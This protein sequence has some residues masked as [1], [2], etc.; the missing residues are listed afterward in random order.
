MR[1][2][3]VLR[4]GTRRNR[5]G[6]RQTIAVS[7]N[8]RHV[9]FDDQQVDMYLKN[10]FDELNRATA[11]NE[12]EEEEEEDSHGVSLSE[13]VPVPIAPGSND[14]QQRRR[15][16]RYATS[17]LHLEKKLDKRLSEL[18]HSNKLHLQSLLAQLVELRTLDT[19]AVDHLAHIAILLEQ[20]QEEQ[21][22]KRTRVEEAHR[23]RR[24][25]HEIYLDDDDG[26]G[27]LRT[28]GCTTVFLD[29]LDDSCAIL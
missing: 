15:Y 19:L 10:I 24:R 17:V 20:E 18:T 1:R 27:D 14:E 5:R 2:L 23:S 4:I 22:Q 12:E 7:P 8:D 21:R 6:R 11:D 25:R 26:D 3:S 16:A 9:R 29:R 13:S 28:C